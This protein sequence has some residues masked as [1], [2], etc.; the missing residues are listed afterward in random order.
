[1][2][3]LLPLAVVA[4]LL[5][6][7]AHAADWAVDGAKSQIKF[8]G[9]QAGAAFTGRFAKWTAKIAF[10][11][12]NVAAGHAEVTIDIASAATGDTQKDEALPQPEWFDAK[13]FPQAK[14]EA[15]SFRALGNDRYEAVG[16][17]TIK[18]TTK[19]AVLPF[20]LKITG[21][22]ADVVGKLEID[23]I[24]FNVGE[25][26]WADPTFVGAKVGLDIALSAKRQ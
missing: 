6:P 19:D 9:T 21:D 15:K 7:A 13:K 1:M 5:S 4:T 8:S 10:D 25:G 17:L 24:A 18:G 2:K 3:F 23:R 20:S 12:A 22:Q 16:S 14:F 26:P 11:P